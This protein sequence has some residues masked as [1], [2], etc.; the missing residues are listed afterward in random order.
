MD[1]DRP[2]PEMVFAGFDGRIHSVDARASA[3]WDYVYTTDERVLTAGVLIVDLSRDGVPEVVFTTYSPDEGKSHLIVL[4][5]GGSE[6]HRIGLPK[7]GA[8]PVPTVA[9]VNGDGN[10]EIIVSLK[11]GEDGERQVLVYTVDNSA[12]NCML[13]TTGR[14]NLQRNGFVP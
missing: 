10:L 4:D 7:R 3:V 14:G 13:W 8:M 5:A 11:D 12:D 6:M 2:G 1:P 9:D